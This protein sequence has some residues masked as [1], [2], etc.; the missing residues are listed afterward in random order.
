MKEKQ[1]KIQWNKSHTN[2]VQLLTVGALMG[3]FVGA[4]IT[5]Y[6]LLFAV[7][8]DYAFEAY[9]IVRDKPWY[10][11]LWIIALAMGVFLIGV[12]ANMSTMLQRC[13]VLQVEGAA[14]AG[15]RFRWFRDATAMCASTIIGVFLGLSIGSEG[16]SR[17]IGAG[18]GNGVGQLTRR[19][20]MIRRYQMTGGACTGFA[21]VCNAPLTGIIFSF[22]ES[23]KRFTSE[24][25][26][27]SFISVIFGMLTHWAIF[28]LL[29]MPVTSFLETYVFQ[30]LPISYYPLVALSA[31]VCGV[32][33]VLLY[34]LCILLHGQFRRIRPKKKNRAL[35]IRIAIAVF[36]GGIAALV[37]SEVIGGGHGLVNALGT[38]AGEKEFDVE[39]VFGLPIFWSLLIIL[40]L[41]MLCTGVNVGAGLPCGIFVPIIAIGA[42]IGGILNGIYA[43]FGFDAKYADFITMI[44]MAAF[45]GAVVKTPLTAMIMICEFTGSF[46]PLLPVIIAVAIGYVIS[47]LC[48]VDGIYEALLELY[49]EEYDVHTDKV[50]RIFSVTVAKHSLADGR[51]IRDVL[52]PEGARVQEIMRGEETFVPDGDSVLRAGDVLK[53]VCKTADEEYTLYDLKGITG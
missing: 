50:N 8:E 19:N 29:H 5:L 11:P 28:T 3:V 52:W 49:E 31:L 10:I 30:D 45:F 47:D 48:R 24:V 27:C 14:R 39:R 22:E 4:I 2:A 34:K 9:A 51:E 1:R 18:I 43:R 21:V 35:F 17:F 42:C 33:G 41:K 53:I 26:I 15:I 40:L 13:G 38:F 46:T 36:V 6:Q 23:Q 7:A 44:C 25:F 37:A 16:P 12:V 20:E 32:L